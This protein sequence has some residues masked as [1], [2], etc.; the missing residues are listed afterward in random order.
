[1]IRPRSFLPRILCQ[2]LQGNFKDFGFRRMNSSFC[3]GHDTHRAK[4]LQIVS[5]YEMQL[6]Q[7]C[8]H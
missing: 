1:L 6:R 5:S 7:S 4:E 3:A 2:I 8:G